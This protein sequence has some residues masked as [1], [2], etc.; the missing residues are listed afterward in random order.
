MIYM[1][2][3]IFLYITYIYM[4]YVYIIHNSGQSYLRNG[5]D[6]IYKK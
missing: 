5:T 4:Y 6:N 1:L 2:R 3:Y